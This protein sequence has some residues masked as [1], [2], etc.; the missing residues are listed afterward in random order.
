MKI[1]Q[2][3]ST[4]RIEYV[5]SDS[6]TIKDILPQNEKRCFLLLY[7]PV[8]QS[9]HNI[10]ALFGRFK[11]F[12]SCFYRSIFDAPF[13]YLV[14]QPIH[15][16]SEQ[17]TYCLFQSFLQCFDMFVEQTKEIHCNVPEVEYGLSGQPD[18][19]LWPACSIP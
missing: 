16:F 6:S 15:A 11:Q 5:P 9:K 12:F 2:T 13:C 18:L 8:S 4:L 14:K 19:D 1:A 10:Y 3:S 7:S 17:V